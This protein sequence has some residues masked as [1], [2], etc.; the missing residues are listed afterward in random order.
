MK[1]QTQDEPKRAKYSFCCCCCLLYKINKIVLQNT[2]YIC[3][4]NKENST[5]TLGDRTGYG[6]YLFVF[7]ST[8]DSELLAW[9]IDLDLTVEDKFHISARPCI[10]LYLLS[11][12]LRLIYH[13]DY[14]QSL[15]FLGSSSKTPETRKWPRAWLKLRRR[16][17]LPLSFLASRVSRLAASPLNARARVHSPYQIWRKGE[18][19]RSLYII[20]HSSQLPLLKK[21][22]ESKIMY[23]ET[24]PSYNQPLYNEKTTV[25]GITFPLLPVPGPDL[26][27]R[28]GAVIQIL[29]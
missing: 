22:R 11:S 13:I 16:E 5:W 28:G 23:N 18:T 9:D 3:L 15:F 17:R 4:C 21:N 2:W 1:I 19:A 26:E 20:C 25:V 27:I 14:E 24:Q 12:A 6:I 7:K 29:T 8:E 10:I